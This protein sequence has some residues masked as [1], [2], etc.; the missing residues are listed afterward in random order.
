MPSRD[1]QNRVGSEIEAIKL[2][3]DPSGPGYMVV[4]DCRK[5]TWGSQVPLVCFGRQIGGMFVLAG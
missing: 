3:E 2:D 5:A 4:S 1:W